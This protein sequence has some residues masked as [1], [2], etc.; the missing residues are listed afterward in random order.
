MGGERAL[1]PDEAAGRALWTAVL[2]P[3]APPVACAADA[4]A[5]AAARFSKLTA[6]SV[7]AWL[8]APLLAAH[9]TLI[10][11]DDV[12]RARQYMRFMRARAAAVLADVAAAGLEVVALKGL[13]TAARFYPD[14]LTR[15]MGDIDLLVRPHEVGRLCDVLEAAGYRFRKSANTPVWG[16]AT[17]SSFHPMVA[18]DGV[19][20][21]DIHVAADD[22]PVPRALGVAD[23]FAAAQPITV[24]D[25][26]VRAPSDDHLL[27]LAITNAGRDKFGPDSLRA[28]ADVVAALARAGFTPDWESMIALARQGGFLRP[29]TAG[30]N[31][32]AHLGLAPERLPV[33]LIRPYRGL[34]GSA[35]DGIVEDY[36]TVFAHRPGRLALQ[37]RDWMVISGPRALAWRNWR[38]VRGLVRPWSGLP[39][40]RALGAS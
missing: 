25:V 28:M 4:L 36:L 11:P 8:A 21:F 20:S 38:R 33:A 9:P 1:S 23:V 12:R 7:A 37:L 2:A 39:P 32:L 24:N 26:A 22:Y 40:G 29:L 34:A 3:G 5:A 19:F 13:A 6:P 14:P 30:V 35:F 27:L 18:A 15:V 10:P 31:I 17:E 16:L